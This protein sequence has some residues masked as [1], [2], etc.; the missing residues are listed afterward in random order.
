ML[1]A[2]WVQRE[3]Q[4]VGSGMGQVCLSCGV[5]GSQAPG[6]SDSS[7]SLSLCLVLQAQI[8]SFAFSREK[9]T[10]GGEEGTPRQGEGVC[11]W[12]LKASSP[13][14]CVAQQITS[15]TR[16]HEDVGSIPGLT[17]WVKDPA[18]P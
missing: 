6:F 2:P 13:S 18:L 1:G 16:I 15:L 3:S 10:L 11:H 12:V 14:S 4:A 17:Q 7:P 8:L 9:N 5:D